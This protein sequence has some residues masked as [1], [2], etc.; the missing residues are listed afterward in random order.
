M[1]Y[2]EILANFI[3]ELDFEKIPQN[4]KQRAKELMLDSF[5]SLSSK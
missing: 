2:S 4:V 3:T 5:H 1:F